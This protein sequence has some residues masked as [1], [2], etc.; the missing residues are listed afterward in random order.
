VIHSAGGGGWGDPAQRTAAQHTA[1]RLA[2][3]V[4]DTDDAA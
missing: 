3:F 1:D 4:T 2:G